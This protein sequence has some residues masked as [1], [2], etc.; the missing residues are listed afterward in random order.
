M[1]SIIIP[2]YGH[3]AFL[4][5][6][7]ESL[8]A[9][10]YQEWEAWV[11]D[12]QSPDRSH[13]IAERFA[14]RDSRIKCLRNEKNLGAYSTQNVGLSLASHDWAAI[15]NSDDFWTP[16][17]LEKQAAL[18]SAYPEAAFCYTMGRLEFTGSDQIADSTYHDD[19]PQEEVHDL[20][21]YLLAENKVLASSLVFRRGALQFDSRMQTS[22]DW[23]AALTLARQGKAL[24]VKEPVTIWRQH[25]SNTS[26][27]IARAIFEQIS[28]RQRVCDCEVE[29][30]KGRHDQLWRRKMDLCRI[31]LSGQYSV[32][33]EAKLARRILGQGPRGDDSVTAQTWRKRQILTYLPRSLS[34]PRLAP[35]FDLQD[36]PLPGSGA[37]DWRMVP[38]GL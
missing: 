1:F 27:S 8:L 31:H 15:L 33:G 12:D 32:I 35:A 30:G 4:E 38:Q 9:Q 11:I 14:S 24:F 10:T 7:L 25:Q 26:K 20:L 2:S 36:L 34:S 3:E 23:V 29:W 19:Y 28:I 21:P 37:Y 22:G 5:E 17:K 18:I 16:D 13:E 6:C